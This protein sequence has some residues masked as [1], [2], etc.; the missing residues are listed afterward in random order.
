VSKHSNAAP[1]KRLIKKIEIHNSPELE[2]ELD[3]L[4]ALDVEEDFLVGFLPYHQLVTARLALFTFFVAVCITLP[5]RALAS[6]PNLATESFH[7]FTTGFSC[8]DTQIS[9]RELIPSS[10]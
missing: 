3:F 5:V 6:S 7:V 9:T 4:L 10:R 2:S 1:G 8:K